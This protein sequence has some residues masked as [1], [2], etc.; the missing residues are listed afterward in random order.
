MRT[1][2]L[3]LSAAIALGAIGTLG[4]AGPA[5]ATTP[6]HLTGTLADGATWVADVPAAWN[7]TLLLFSHG[8]GPTTAQDAPND[9][10]RAALLAQ[11]YA[12]AGSSYDPNGSWWAL[13]SAERDQF[14]TL[15]AFAKASGRRPR[16]TLSVGV[17]MGGLVNAR[18]ARDGAGRVDGALGFC[19]LVAGGIDLSNY[20][21]DAEYTLASLLL[22]GT[23]VKL[24]GYASMAEGATAAQQLTAAVTAAQATAP[25]R[26]RIALA[27][28]Y[29]NLPDWVLGQNPPA[30]G[31]AAAQEAQQYAWIA[32]GVL[33][34]IIPARYSIEQSAGGNT[35]WNVG[36]D[37]RA[38]LRDSE[39]AAEVR[40][41]YRAAGLNLRT[42][43]A[44][45]TRGAHL[46]ADPAAVRRLQASSTAGQ[47]LA[48]PLLDVHTISDQL[49]AVQQESVFAARVRAT[50]DG[51]LLRQ[52]YVS[53][54]SHCNFTAAEIVAG[55]QAIDQRV[56]TGRWGNLADPASLQARA[57]SLNLDGAA[58]IPY[59]PS[60]LVVGRGA[61]RLHR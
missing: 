13:N 21:Y 55:V 52:A 34:F 41:L 7:G 49:V 8:Y 39:H 25:G 61:Y 59:R 32:Q 9:P 28:A 17:S 24:T 48:V 2:K 53:R 38:L 12:M 19:G 33:S 46:R 45:L 31:D 4:S 37:Y 50:G 6:T 54:Q 10:S 60:R 35:S 58:F 15:D 51:G 47:H 26:A 16:R 43:L 42:D 36:V 18:I 5:T 56:T 27:A 44:K 3:L 14:G 40:S 23:P 57:T 22:P 30:A 11:G 20:Q 1:P 29:L